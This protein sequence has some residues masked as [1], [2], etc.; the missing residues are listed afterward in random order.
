MFLLLKNVFFFVQVK[1]SPDFQTVNVFWVCKGTT[2]DEET[3]A[4]L[5]R[6]SGPLR[7]E[8]STLRVMGEVPYITFAKGRNDN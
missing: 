7:H 4:A 1:I 5:K 3:A 6:I 8:L 2:T